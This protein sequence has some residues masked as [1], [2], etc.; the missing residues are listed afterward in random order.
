MIT[1]PSE[2]VTMAPKHINSCDCFYAAPIADIAK[3]SQEITQVT[4]PGMLI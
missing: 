4:H 2:F 3:D 1:I